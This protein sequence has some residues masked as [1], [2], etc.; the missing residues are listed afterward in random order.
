M[1]IDAIASTYSTD[2]GKSVSCS[3]VSTPK[4]ETVGPNGIT[5]KAMNAVVA[6]ITG[7]IQ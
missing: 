1:P 7:A 4:I 3:G 5:A 2:T 6:E